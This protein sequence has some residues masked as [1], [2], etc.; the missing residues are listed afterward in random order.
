MLRMRNPIQHYAWG[1]REVLARIQ[2][3]P[4]PSPEPEAELW[5]GAHPSAPSVV[6]LDGRERPLDELLAEEP[7]RFLRDAA[8]GD[9]L[10]CLMKI[11][12]IDAPLSI[13]VHPSPEQAAEGFAREERA[14]IPLGDPRRNYKDR[15]AK[16][17]TVVALTDLELLTGVQP[18]GRLDAVAQRLR[19]GWLREALAAGG[20]VLPAVL[21]LPDDDAAAAVEAT[22]AAAR[23]AGAEDPVARLIRYV[24]D[25][26]PGDR[27]LL[28]AVCMHHLR[29]A[30]GQSVHTPAGQLHAYLSGA[31][32][33]VMSSSDNV[34][35]AGLTGKHVD[36]PEVLRVLSEEQPP[37]EVLDPPA[38]ADGSRRYPLWDERLALVAHEAAPGRTVPFEVRGTA[39]LLAATGRV[40]VRAAG[41][42]WELG[43][44]DSL[45][46][47]GGPTAVELSGDGRLFTVLC[48]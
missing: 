21:G 28:V 12:A 39:M 33:E 5:V 46:H 31:A 25:R 26:H 37:P 6:H 17:E 40:R 20:P 24:A 2:G 1:S 19:L 35:R 29:L 41:R 45:L 36:V 34:L 4:V 44:G 47:T 7:G 42:T 16:P 15:S 30:P 11:L 22:V 18:A 27:G 8:A 48:G 3:R 14:G 23:A 43:G 10:P 9:G 32:V 13:Q 38:A